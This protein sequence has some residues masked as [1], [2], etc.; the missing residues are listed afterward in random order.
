MTSEQTLRGKFS[1]GWELGRTHRVLFK[2]PA[3]DRMIP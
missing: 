3:H 1:P 2:H